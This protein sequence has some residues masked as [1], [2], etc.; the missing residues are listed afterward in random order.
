[1]KL[2]KQQQE[3]VSQIELEEQ[4]EAALEEFIK[5]GG[6]AAA[7]YLSGDVAYKNT[8]KIVEWA[9]ENLPYGARS[10][11]TPSSFEIAFNNCK[12]SLVPDPKW[13]SAKELYTELEVR[14]PAAQF[15]ALYSGQDV[16]LSGESAALLSNLGGVGVFREFVDGK[17]R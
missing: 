7:P 2:S 11:T 12:S 10:L 6:D 3:I 1:M 17:R 15:K 8:H 14:L 9:I 13:R 4:C 5:Q 16:P